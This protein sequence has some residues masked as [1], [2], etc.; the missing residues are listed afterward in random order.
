MKRIITLLMIFSSVIFSKEIKDIDELSKLLIY[1]KNSCSKNNVDGCVEN[2]KLKGGSMIDRMVDNIKWLGHASIM[3][4]VDD[5][6]IFI[7]PWKI[8]EIKDKADII[9]ITHSH[10]DHYSEE[11]IKKVAKVDSVIYGPEDVISKTSLKNKKVLKPYDEIKSGNINIKAFPAYNLNKNFHPKE[12]KWLGYIIEYNGVSIYI[13]GD[14][15]FIPEMRELKVNI[16]IL[17][18]GG[19]YT[20]N[21]KESANFTN[22]IK[23]DV[24]I[25]IHW[26]DIVGSK[27]DVD[28]FIKNVKKPTKV[29]LK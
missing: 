29:V 27:K 9:L 22:T 13:A 11:D 6:N 17:P 19:T 28:E 24:A 23:P 1:T 25:P 20:M 12:N 7:D 21:A 26:G 4:K 8:K 18:V 15:D 2:I 10:F 14:T 3:I 5:K 16:V